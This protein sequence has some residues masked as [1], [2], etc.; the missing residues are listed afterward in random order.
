MGPR[1]TE[2]PLSPGLRTEQ[3][4]EQRPATPRPAEP[5]SAIHAFADQVAGGAGAGLQPQQNVRSP[6][7]HSAAPAHS[8]F[9]QAVATNTHESAFKPSSKPDSGCDTAQQ[10]KPES[11]VR[12]VPAGV[13]DYV[14]STDVMLEKQASLLELQRLRQQG[15]RLSKDFTMDDSLQSMQFE[16]RRHVMELQ[17]GRTLGLMRDGMSLFFTGMEMANQK[18]GPVLDLNGWAAEVC[19]DKERFDPALARLYRKYYRRS[20]MSAEM[21]LLMA[22]GASA[23]MFHMSK[24]FTPPS[25][26]GPRAA[27]QGPAVNPM[28]FASMFTSMAGGAAAPPREQEARRASREGLP[29]DL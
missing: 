8:V 7:A 18:W 2:A 22:V 15:V 1:R 19:K 11:P 6:D 23:V 5:P 20:Q 25:V 26:G 24:K 29:P 13:P 27:A 9:Q 3:P 17:E 4:P 10:R 14:D 16:I 12:T 28:E 21:E